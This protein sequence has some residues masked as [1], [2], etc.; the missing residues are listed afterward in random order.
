M[1]WI[2]NIDQSTILSINLEFLIFE[3]GKPLK[4]EAKFMFVYT[5]W[6][7]YFISISQGANEIIVRGQFPY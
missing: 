4:E 7:S 6:I 5:L 1:I 3:L 2:M